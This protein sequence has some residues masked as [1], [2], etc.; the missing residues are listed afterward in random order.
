M[1]TRDINDDM[2]SSRIL[3]GYDLPNETAIQHLYNVGDEAKPMGWQGLASCAK[4]A[5]LV[6][7]QVVKRVKPD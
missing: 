1:K 3:A 2:P 5:I 4:G 7:D 6:A